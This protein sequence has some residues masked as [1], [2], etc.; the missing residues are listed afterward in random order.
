MRTLLSKYAILFDGTLGEWNTTPVNLVLKAGSEAFQ[1]KPFDVPRIHL[2]T[3]KKEIK[4]LCRIGVLRRVAVAEYASPSFIIP[5]KNGTVRVV[6]DFRVL[7]SLLKTVTFPIPKIQD[8]LNDLGGFTYA[9]S[10][11]LNMGYYTI[12][13][14]PQASKL[15]TIVFPFG[16]FEYLRLPMGV[17]TSPSIFQSKIAEL[18]DGLE[19]VR[20]YLDDVLLITK[21]DFSDHLKCLETVLQ[22]IK[23]ANLRI[24]VD[25]SFFATS[26]LEYLGYKVTRTGLRPIASKVEAIQRLQRPKTLRQLR[27]FLGMINYYRD[28]WKRRSHMMAPLSEAT[29]VPKGS[30]TLKWGPEQDKAFENIKKHITANT[31]L[32]FPDLNKPFDIHTDASDTQ[33]GAVLSQ[34]RQ[35]IAFY[36]RKLNP[37]Q[38]NYTVGEREMLSIVETLKEYR[39]ILL[40]RDI[41]IYTD[42]MNLVRTSTTSASPRV[43]RWRALVEEFSPVFKYIKGPNNVVADALSRLDADYET[44][45][46][47]QVKND[48]FKTEADDEEIAFPLST[49]IIAAQQEKCASLQ[50]LRSH[51]ELVYRTIHGTKVLVLK[52]KIFIPKVLRNRVLNWYHEM[53]RHPGV[54]RTERTIRQHL[55]WPGLSKDVSEHVAACPQCQKCKKARKKYGHLPAKTFDEN[56]WD[57]VCVDQIGPYTVIN[58]FGKEMVLNAM[59]MCDPATGWFEIVEVDNKK[60]LTAAKLLDRVWFC[61]YPRPKQ[62][63]HDNGNEFTGLEFQELLD[64]Y[65]V[66]STPTT[67]KNPQANL[68]ERVHQTPGN[69]LRT[70]E[71]EK[72]DFDTNDPWSDILTSCAW[73]IRATVHT[74]LDATPAQLIYGRDMLYDLSFTRPWDSAKRKRQDAIEKSNIRENKKRIKYTYKEGDRILLDRGILQRKLSPLRDGPYDVVRVYP[75]GTLQ[76]KKGVYTQRVSIRR[77]TPFVSSKSR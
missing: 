9:T 1:L 45:I 53:L 28:M 34:N 52:D 57:T 40:G 67:V 20:A 68:V 36:S 8:L 66:K 31:M 30:R 37:A 64:S 41:T 22:R 18:M 58:Q 73:A 17:K 15:C 3:L 19:F 42:H 59:T 46:K 6:S 32:K 62:C 39:T 54:E 49:Q 71:L 77:C 43:Q 51:P 12:R 63:I 70:Y 48:H 10:L 16:T 27:S 69:M 2:D 23:K 21:S 14:T 60:S 13:L 7:N 38:K 35:P 26:E 56:P 29:K 72:H 50:K 5:K 76:I 65:G 25:K 55:V 75:N 11:D 33:L 61:R 44:P 4:R 24:N 74:V 47:E